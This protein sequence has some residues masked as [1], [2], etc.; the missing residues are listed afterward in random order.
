MY[1]EQGF[2]F[3]RPDSYRDLH[4]SADGYVFLFHHPTFYPGHL[5]GNFLSG[6]PD[7]QGHAMC[8]P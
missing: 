4:P 5:P 1:Q 7:E 6:S 3:F 2:T 8:G